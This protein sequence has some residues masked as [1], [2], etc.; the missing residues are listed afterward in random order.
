M[1]QLAIGD[2]AKVKCDPPVSHL[3]EGVNEEAIS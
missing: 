3:E 1:W 2:G